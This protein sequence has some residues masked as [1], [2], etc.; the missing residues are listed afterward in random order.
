[1]TSSYPKELRIKLT[2]TC[3]VAAHA[4]PKDL[5]HLRRGPQPD[6]DA[7]AAQLKIPAHEVIVPIDVSTR[8]P[9]TLRRSI[10]TSP[11]PPA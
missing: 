7:E 11:R 10:G 2:R 3:A 6:M 9:S 5:R 8:S 1:M 4:N